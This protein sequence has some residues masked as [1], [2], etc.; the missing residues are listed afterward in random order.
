[1]AFTRLSRFAFVKRFEIPS[2]GRH[3]TNRIFSRFQEF[4]ESI[5][6]TNST[7][8][9]ATNPNDGN[10]LLELW[11]ACAVEVAGVSITIHRTFRRHLDSPHFERSIKQRRNVLQLN[12]QRD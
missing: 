5:W 11:S 3:F 10:R 12:N 6:C 7:R 2:G 1:M 8:Q 9:A 4:P